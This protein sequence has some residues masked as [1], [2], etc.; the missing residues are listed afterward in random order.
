MYEPNELFKFSAY[1]KDKI[2][3]IQE[4][5]QPFKKRGV[6]TYGELYAKLPVITQLF[7]YINK[8][9]IRILKKY[10]KEK[11]NLFVLAE[12]IYKKAVDFNS[13]LVY[14]GFRPPNTK[15]HSI[16]RE[17]ASVVM[18]KTKKIFRKYRNVSNRNVSKVPSLVPI[19][20][21]VQPDIMNRLS[22]QNIETPTK[23]NELPQD[24]SK[25]T[26]YGLY[27]CILI[28]YCLAIIYLEKF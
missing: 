27:I 6:E 16:I 4:V 23:N 12:V 17:N 3:I 5:S 24:L 21:E 19:K 1:C 15:E 10:G 11:S 2:R 14:K 25:S 8:N 13:T 28:L 22:I 26:F 20:V 18:K 9:F 7:K